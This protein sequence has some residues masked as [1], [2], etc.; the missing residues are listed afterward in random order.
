VVSSLR[1]VDKAASKRGP[2]G[3]YIDPIQAV[4]LVNGY[5]PVVPASP[6][7]SIPQHF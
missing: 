7:P 4:D 1:K 2:N 3:D 5:Q 6:R